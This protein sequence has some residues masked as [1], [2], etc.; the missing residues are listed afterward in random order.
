ML[1]RVDKVPQAEEVL[2]EVFNISNYQVISNDTIH[3]YEQ[4][5][6]KGQLMK[7]FVINDINV[8]EMTEQGEGLEAYYMSLIRKK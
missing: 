7:A 4:L 5:D 6:Q 1:L 8:E 2:H 3:L